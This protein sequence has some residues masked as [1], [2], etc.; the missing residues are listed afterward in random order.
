MYTNYPR[1]SP[2]LT[3]AWQLAKA[4]SSGVRFRQAVVSG[5]DFAI[6]NRFGKD[7]RCI[8]HYTAKSTK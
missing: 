5:G 1:L 4:R 6:P 7:K 3:A 8:L 2:L